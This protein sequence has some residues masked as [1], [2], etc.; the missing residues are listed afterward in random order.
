MKYKK[1]RTFTELLFDEDFN[2]FK[3]HEKIEIINYYC[4]LCK[5][6]FKKKYNLERHNICLHENLERYKCNYCYK[7]II[8]KDNLKKH[9][10][11]RC[12]KINNY[13]L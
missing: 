13:H 6:Y 5:K 1:Y 10:L 3:N 11:N 4:L 12:K 7:K 8:R 9:Q 2:I